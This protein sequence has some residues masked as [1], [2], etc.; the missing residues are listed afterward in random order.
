MTDDDAVVKRRPGRK[1]RLARDAVV[2]AALE[3][4]ETEGLERLSMR[5]LGR[6]LGIEAMALYTYVQSKDDLLDAVAV[7]VL[8]SLEL[9]DPDADWESRIRATVSCWAGMQ[10]THPRAFPLVYRPN[11]PTDAVGRTTEHLLDALRAAGFDEAGTALA[12]QTLVCFLD[13][14]LLGWP[15]ESYRADEAWGRA[16]GRIDRSRYPRMA[17][18]APY[19]AELGWDDV[20]ESGLDLLLRGLAARRPSA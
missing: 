4:V 15:P 18:V 12:Y 5:R 7:R 10:R 9:P 3:L 14:A 2:D 19:A 16:A 17:E 13:G 20:W 8:S 11:L 1:R 6:R